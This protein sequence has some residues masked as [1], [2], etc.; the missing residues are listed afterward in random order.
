MTTPGQF[1]FQVGQPLTYESHQARYGVVFEDDGDTG[2]VYAVE[3]TPRKLR[4]SKLQIL[5][6]FHVYNAA[7]VQDTGR[8]AVGLFEWSADK[9]AVA[10]IVA[11]RTHVMIDFGAALAM[12]AGA[13]PPPTADSPFQT[14]LWNE[15]AFLERF[16]H[17]V[18]EW[19]SQHRSMD[20]PPGPDDPDD[21]SVDPPDADR[22]ARR[23][24]ILAA[25]TSRG[26]IETDDSLDDPAAI[27]HEDLAF[28][29]DLRLAADMEPD[30]EELVAAPHGSLSHQ[31]RV[32]AIWRTEGLG[33]LAWALGL[34]DRLPRIDE[35]FSPPELGSALGLPWTNGH[36]VA[37]LESPQLRAAAE[38]QRLD[39]VLR[40]AHWRVREFQLRPDPVDFTKMAADAW[41]GPLDLGD[42]ELVD[43]D[44]AIRGTPIARAD[45]DLVQMV[46]S[47]LTER[48]LATSWLLGYDALYSEGDV[49][50]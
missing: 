3:T 46:S 44:L 20:D 1:E 42:L 25:V 19:S 36:D 33:V 29:T 13:F 21:G 14:K 23:A 37:F 49:N 32:D 4:S 43:G 31:D 8:P 30:E 27:L 16:P 9:V 22:V 26:F 2:Y 10:F 41:W 7:D 45:P 28:V 39:D 24:A 47:I 40:T 12:S 50:T 6:A 48:R 34:V 15:E 11:G 5:D 38:F 17:L 35:T 18:S